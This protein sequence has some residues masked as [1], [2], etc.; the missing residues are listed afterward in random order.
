MKEKDYTTMY[1][2]ER[3]NILIYPIKRTIDGG[4]NVGCVVQY[5]V[6]RFTDSRPDRIHSYTEGKHSY[7]I[8]QRFTLDSVSCVLSY[9]SIYGLDYTYRV[10]MENDDDLKNFIIRVTNDNPEYFI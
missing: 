6:E 1:V 4:P 10:L 5:Y 7:E 9:F 3:K 2:I 8:G